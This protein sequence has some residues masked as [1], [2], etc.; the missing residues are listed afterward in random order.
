[1]I[2]FRVLLDWFLEFSNLFYQK[3]RHD[4]MKKIEHKQ[5]A[6]NRKTT[7]SKGLNKS[8]VYLVL[9]FLT[10]LQLSAQTGDFILTHHAPLHSEIDNV[11]FQITSD[12]NG[13]ICVANR[14]G[15]LKYDGAEWNFHKTN[16][17][18]ISLVVDDNNDVFI[19]CIG[20]FGKMDFREN[21]YR[22]VS[23]ID[24]DSLMD[25]FVQ[26][27]EFGDL[28]LF[29]SEKNLYTYRTKDGITTHISS[30]Q[31]T[32][33]YVLDQ[34]FFV[35][36]EDG[37]T[38][39]FDGK[40]LLEV[41]VQ[42]QAWGIVRP[43]PAD[44]TYGLSLNSE[45]FDLNTGSKIPQNQKFE[46]A[47]VVISDFH[48]VNDSLIACSTVESGIIFLNSN[49]PTYFEVTDYHTGLPDNEVHDIYTD[50]TGG[51]W[52]SHDFGFTRIAP[53]FPA[54]SYTNFP[55]LEGNL[56]EAQRVH[57][58]IW[59]TSSSGVFYFKQDTSYQRRVVLEEKKSKAV[60]NPPKETTTKKPEK[61]KDKKKGFLGGIFKRKNRAKET[62]KE[63]KDQGLIKKIFAGKKQEVEY[64]RRVHQIMSGISYQ[65][66]HVEGT[67]GKFKQLFETPSKILGSSNTGIYEIS[68]SGA[69]LVIEG[70]IL[71]AYA[72]PNQNQLVFST[73]EGYLKSYE[74]RNNAWEQLSEQEFND[75]ILNIYSDKQGRVWLAGTT[76]IYEGTFTDT[77]FTLSVSYEINNRFYD[78]LSIVEYDEKIYFINSQGYFL[79]D[80][81]KNRIVRDTKLA[82]EVGLPHHHLHN[83]QK[84][85]W[86]YDGKIWN[87]LDG[88]QVRRFN[89]LGIYPDLKYVSYDP[90]LDRYWLITADNQLLAYR[91]EDKNQAQQPHNLFVK[92]ISSGNSEL[93]IQ[94]NF[95][96]AHDQNFLS[97]E[98]LQPDFLR[99]LNPEYQYKLIGLNDDWSGWTHANL[100]EYSYLP[101]G[102][103]E[104]HVRTKDSFGR[105]EESVLLTFSVGKPYWKQPWFYAIQI[106]IL[107]VIVTITSRLNEE[108]PTNRI[109]KSGLSI[110]TLVV[111]IEFLQSV[112]GGLVSA[113]STPVVDF[114]IDVSTAIM[115]FPLE[116]VLR[117]MWLEGG[118][119][120]VR[121]RR[122][123]S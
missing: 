30:G 86:I 95:K 108:N 101:S 39:K 44:L 88:G 8:F 112:L 9:L 77:G 103:Y 1:M 41:E 22:Y 48:W 69:E 46:E 116:W 109:I 34:E 106:L 42:G 85:V 45:L 3:E 118:M 14:F 68:K 113:Q 18:A 20:D 99:I 107:A 67:D 52:V 102:K 17:S 82:K 70:H 120:F 92:K 38:L 78:E 84:R 122:V 32:N 74:L 25:H 23:L 61:N 60:R 12:N 29:L 37:K 105:M 2:S 55:G 26:T 117:K 72:L 73:D 58:D 36:S 5:R 90:V 27:I 21:E 59:V 16:S 114:L 65:F 19:G 111:I 97:I 98:I 51:V 7:C 50:D 91:H 104:L 4:L 80:E 6:N 87:L 100:I 63:N 121:P 123:P 57:G 15:L 40:Q 66:V 75:A 24:S 47:Q 115:V 54:Y 35:N 96:L 62:D 13:I 64:V 53:L 10:S 110:L 31:F 89:Y 43:S 79:F 28:V 119:R 76:N 83:E 33:G 71:Y 56:I 81:S 94:R 93:R 49:D 11:N